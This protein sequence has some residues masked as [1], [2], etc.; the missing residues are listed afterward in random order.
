VEELEVAGDGWQT[1]VLLARQPGVE[2]E[3]LEEAGDSRKAMLLAALLQLGKLL[4]MHA[5]GVAAGTWR[6]LRR[7]W[8]AR[9][10]RRGGK[11]GSAVQQWWRQLGSYVH[12]QRCG[13]RQMSV[14]AGL[15]DAQGGDARGATLE[16]ATPL[17]RARGG[18]T[19]GWGGSR[20]SCWSL[21]QPFS[22][23]SRLP[24]QHHCCLPAASSHLQFLHSTRKYH[25]AIISL[26]LPYLKLCPLPAARPW[27]YCKRL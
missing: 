11:G 9:R 4:A 5:G 23:H 3:W 20:T 27:S 21:L 7:R 22:L 12:Q 2:V 10:G 26:P 25:C 15:G 18:S 6:L 1:T 8:E 17:V 16:A 24:C 14:E 13:G 19:N